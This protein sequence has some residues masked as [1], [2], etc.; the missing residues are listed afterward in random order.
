[1]V[2]SYFVVLGYV[3]LEHRTMFPLH[4]T[5]LFK[6]TFLYFLTNIRFRIDCPQW[7]LQK[8]QIHRDCNGMQQA[9][10]GKISSVPVEDMCSSVHRVDI[11]GDWTAGS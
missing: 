7:I 8:Q 10:R 2:F 11:N 5:S 4:V 1:V 3:I 9:M 6:V